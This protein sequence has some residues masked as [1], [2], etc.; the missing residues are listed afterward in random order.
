MPENVG[1]SAKQMVE[2][3]EEAQEDEWGE[4]QKEW[5]QPPP[6]F[7]SGELHLGSPSDRRA[8]LARHA[9][10][11]LGLRFARPLD[12]QPLRGFQQ[13]AGPTRTCFR[14]ISPLRLR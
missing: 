8:S 14:P 9:S 13:P 11:I 5:T 4:D 3:C 12:P 1:A 6:R 10:T 2:Q 7:G